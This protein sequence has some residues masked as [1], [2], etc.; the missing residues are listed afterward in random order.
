MKRSFSLH[1]VLLTWAAAMICGGF[2]SLAAQAADNPWVV[3]EGDQGPGKGKHV[4]F[5]LGDDE[6]KSEECMPQLAQILAQR[7]GFKCTVLFAVNKQTGV[8]DTNTKDNIPGLEALDNADLMVMFTRFREL[9]DDQMKHII[10]YGKSGRPVIGL[11]TATHAFN[12]GK[13]STSAYKQYGWT[14]REPGFEGGWGKMILGET[15]VAHHGAH[16][17][18]SARAVFA[19][20]MASHPI[21]RGVKD[22]EIWGPCDVYR[23]NLPLSADC[24]PL[25]LGQ[26]LVGM[27]PDDKALENSPKNDPMM[28]VAWTKVNPSGQ[29]KPERVFTTTMGGAMA[30]GRD[31]ANEGLRR[32]LVNAAYWAVGLESKIPEKADVA[33]IVDPSPFKRG[34]KPQEAI[35]K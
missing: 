23:V 5:V 27:K 25:L 22:G 32:L 33:Y 34:V 9:P 20:N 35:A 1:R 4:V 3:F 30:G 31:M 17:K 11:R 21:L 6:Y 16:G 7:H 24:Q 13:N 12:Y 26:V 18:E 2:F 15:W 8:I 28:P 19:P 29:G 10:D 14:S